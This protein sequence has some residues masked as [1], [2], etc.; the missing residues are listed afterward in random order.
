MNQITFYLFNRLLKSHVYLQIALLLTV[1]FCGGSQIYAQNIFNSG[2]TGADGAFAPSSNQTIQLP[3]SGV[4]NFTTINIPTGVTISFIPNSQNT[5][6]TLLA[7]G[8]V[9]ISGA[10]S[11]NGEN[12]WT[13]GMGGKG[14]PGGYRGGTGGLI[15]DYFGGTTGDGRGGGG[16]GG[17]NN[18]VNPGGGGGGG[19]S[20]PGGS[21]QTTT[22]YPN[23]LVGYAGPAYGTV[24][25]LP[26]VGGSGGGGGGSTASNRGSAGGGGGGAILIASSGT[27][28]FGGVIYAKGGN[29]AS[30]PA[31]GTGGGGSG[32]AVRLISNTISGTGAIDVRGGAYGTST[33]GSI[34]PGGNG[35][36]GFI[37]AEAYD[38]SAF[39]PN[40]YSVP[41]GIALPN[42]ISISNEPKLR[43]SQIAGV[44]VPLS[45]RGSLQSSPDIVL[46]GS[47][48][49]PV[50]LQ[51][52]A[53]NLPLGS[54]VQVTITPPNGSKTVSQSTP[55]SGTTNASSATASVNLPAG[56]SIITVTLTVN[57][58]TAKL[59]P[60]YIEGEKINSIE[61][62]AGLGGK[63]ETTYLTQSGR[64][65]KFPG[66]SQ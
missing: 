11:L 5:P 28:T 16:G 45:T 42:P 30:A 32:G 43:I 65:L 53:T 35:A 12:G 23:A 57:L 47:L 22:S 46:P 14:G 4:F 40:L 9:T 33:A 41:I 3:E 56:M 51:I 6:V 50:E 17:S 48:P 18:G 7:S 36:R 63:S 52:E 64:R 1:V 49:N 55:L 24:S 20:L 66:V 8:N 10:I 34:S 60:M 29:G 62:A 27:I 37:R 26:L 61:I 44:S 39:N 31:G 25:L 13:T 21:G 19:F 58:Q 38:Y 54:I 15:V 59:H 2:S